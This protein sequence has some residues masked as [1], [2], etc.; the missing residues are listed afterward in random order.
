M[1]LDL[2]NQRTRPRANKIL[3]G[4]GGQTAE[5]AYRLS[6]SS[7]LYAGS[8]AVGL[9]AWSRGAGAGVAGVSNTSTS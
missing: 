6:G 5:L 2:T 1:G 3:E 4:I 9:E 8:G 7:D